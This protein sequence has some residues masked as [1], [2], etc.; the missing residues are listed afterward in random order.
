MQPSSYKYLLNIYLCDFIST[1][2]VFCL[3][4]PNVIVQNVTENQQYSAV[5]LIK[6]MHVMQMLFISNSL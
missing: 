1:H 5:V 3:Y 6:C 2:V 4:M